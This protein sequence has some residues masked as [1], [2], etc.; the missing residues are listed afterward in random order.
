MSIT[1][2][3]CQADNND[4]KYACWN[5]WAVLPRPLTEEDLITND[6]KGKNNKKNLNAAPIEVATLPSDPDVIA[7]PAP[8]KAGLFGGLGKKKVE[9]PVMPMEGV[10][11]IFSDFKDDEEPVA[12]TIAD[13][14][15][16][17]TGNEEKAPAEDIFATDFEIIPEP[18]KEKKGMF[19]FGAK[20]PVQTTTE[21]ATTTEMPVDNETT[22]KPE[23]KG[24]FGFGAKK[25]VQVVTDTV[26]TE[27]PVIAD[28]VSETEPEPEAK[29][30]K[31]GLFGLGK[32]KSENIQPIQAPDVEITPIIPEATLTTPIVTEPTTETPFVFDNIDLISE[33]VVKTDEDK[34][35]SVPDFI[36]FGKIGR[37]HV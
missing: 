22:V 29:P 17:I 21:T 16:E 8:K 36:D 10:E 1:C 15:I 9:E 18:V 30:V 4:I 14:N 7:P 31:K 26:E 37:A 11:D 6:Q 33:P 2:S 3:R 19:G 23:K 5:C 35:S 25:P 34:S 27:L 20:K 13:T 24:L 28:F 32:G 12:T